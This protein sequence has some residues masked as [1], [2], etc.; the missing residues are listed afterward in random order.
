MIILAALPILLKMFALSEEA[1]RYAY[2]LVMIHD[3]MAIFMWPTSFTLPNA[4]RAAGDVKY[5]MFVSIFSMFIFRIIFSVILG[6]GLDWGAIGVW[7]AMVFD[8]I[9]RCT[10]FVLRFKKGKWLEY[11]VI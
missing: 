3:G 2:I 4:L 7:I 6:I 11:K 10:M 5:C 8:W 1:Y 9:F